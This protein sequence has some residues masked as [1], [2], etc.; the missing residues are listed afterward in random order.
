MYVGNRVER[1]RKSLTPDQW[2]YVPTNA[3]P[4]DT[5][6]RSLTAAQL[7]SSSWIQGPVFLM[8]E[9]TITQDFPLTHPED[10]VELRPIQI[11]KTDVIQSQLLGSHRFERFSSWRRLVQIIAQLQ[12]I[13]RSFHSG[14]HNEGWH[15]CSIS[16]NVEAYEHA[17]R[18]AIIQVQHEVY[19]EDICCIL[20]NEHLPQKSSLLALDPVI[21]GDGLLRMGGRLDRSKNELEFR[22]PIIIPGRHHIA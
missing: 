2:N 12:H 8:N 1:I 15:I 5:A 19:V 11:L 13:A 3:N 16:R 21:D 9:P 10:D 7:G 22:N 6:T 20:N 4:A 17:E 18:F 14:T